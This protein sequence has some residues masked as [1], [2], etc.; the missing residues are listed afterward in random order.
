MV[1]GKGPRRS[2]TIVQLVVGLTLLGAAVLAA[3]PGGLETNGVEDQQRADG[4]LEGFRQ[5]AEGP[6][7]IASELEDSEYRLSIPSLDVDSPLV[8]VQTDDGVLGIPKD[9]AVVGWWQDGAQPGSAQ[10]T[11]VLAG[12]V[13]TAEA[14]PGAL[15]AL[16]A[17]R[18]GDPVVVSGWGSDVEYRIE[19]IRRYPKSELPSSDVFAQDGEHRLAIVSCEDLDERSGEY[20]SNIIAFATPITKAPR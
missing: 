13:N 2:R 1:R 6:T 18:P 7:V 14:G 3:S 9:P 11:A 19:S 12:H 17:V 4:A 5:A 10:G 8:S 16:P 20:R 15:F